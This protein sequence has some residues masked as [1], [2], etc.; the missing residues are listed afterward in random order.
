MAD[1]HG[2]TR[3]VMV[4]KPIFD[5]A[6]FEQA[7]I[8]AVTVGVEQSMNKAFESA[9]ADAP[10]RAVFKRGNWRRTR[11][12]RSR[13]FK[14]DE[15]NS[16]DAI[17]KRLFYRNRNGDVVPMR[18]AAAHINRTAGLPAPVAANNPYLRRAATRKGNPNSFAP[19]M[20]SPG[21]TRQDVEEFRQIQAELRARGYGGG[22][23]LSIEYEKPTYG[24]RELNRS[25]TGLKHFPGQRGM[26]PDAKGNYNKSVLDARGRYDVRTG[27]ANFTDKAGVTTVGGRLRK[28]IRTVGPVHH[29]NTIRAQVVSPVRYSKFQEFGTRHNRAHPYMRPAILKLTNS[30]RAEMVKAI[31]RISFKT[32]RR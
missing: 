30:Y 3:G 6:A 11:G 1:Y 26:K 18:S 24:G 8:K 32:G 14:L 25:K 17:R 13:G 10:V 9:V 5:G 20:L 29:L 4:G 2:T 16:E 22:D 7:I 27:R 31:N 28:S 19:F 15:A 21:T 23:E 12:G